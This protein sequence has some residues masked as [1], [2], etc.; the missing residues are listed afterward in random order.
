MPLSK[1]QN[2]EVEQLRASS[3]TTL[4]ATVPS[5]EEILYKPLPA[6]DHGFVR[7]VDYMGDD[8]AIVQSAR[9]SYGK[10]TKKISNDKGLIKYLMRHWHSTP[11]EMCEIKLHVKLPIFIARQWIRHRTAN[12]NEYSARYSILDKEFYIPSVENLASQSQVNKQGRAESLSSEEAEK[13]ITLL[14]NDAEQTYRNYEVMLNENSEGE[15]EKEIPEEWLKLMGQK[16]LTDEEKKMVESLGG[17]DKLMETLK[18][19]LE[20]QKKRHQGGSKWIGTGGTSPFGAYGYNPEGIRIGQKESRNKK[21]VKVWDKREFSNLDGDVELGTRNIKVALRRLRKFAREG[22]ETELDLD[23]TIKSTA[24]KGY[25]DVKMMPERRNKIK[26]LLFFDVGGSMDAHVK[27]CEELFSAARTEFKHMEYFYY[28]NCLYDAVW[29]DNKRRYNENI[30]TWDLLHKYPSD[31]KV[32]FVGDAEMSPY[33][34]TYP[35]GS[36]EFWN[37]ESGETWLT[38]LLNVYENAIWLNPIP[39]RY[40]DRISSASIIK[41]IFSDRMF[42]LTIEGIDQAMR[43]LN[44]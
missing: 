44:K 16:Y 30:K 36:V 10:G 39:E 20:E 21:A 31:Y 13:V 26:V 24:H 1:E 42:P 7:V 9:V 29:K 12:V 27:I 15:T 22:V 25:I 28:H 6:L 14:K 35:G 43:E 18:Q 40:W 23:N 32:I 33:E 5:L 11:F 38:R 17:W 2:D 34:I 41:Q 8:T 4:R 19:R 3:S 37:E